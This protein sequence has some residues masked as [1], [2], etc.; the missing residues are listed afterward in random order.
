[1]KRCSRCKVEKD[2][3]QFIH[4]RTKCL[5]CYQKAQ[6]YYSKHRAREIAR[7]KFH[8]NKDR[9]HTNEMKRNGIRKN[10]IS[11][12]LWQVKARAKRNNIPFN[13]THDDIVIPSICPVLGIPIQISDGNATWN[14]PS[15]DRHNPQLG[16][17]TGNISIISHRANTIKSDASVKE[18]QQVLAYIQSLP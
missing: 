1:M 4:G 11:Y 10:P 9:A 6:K 2:D 7:A 17:I 3:D 16:Y 13:L 18:L 14:S 12:I 8:L 15:V 5:T